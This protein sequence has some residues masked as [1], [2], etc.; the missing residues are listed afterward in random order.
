MG[1]FD[2]AMEFLDVSSFSL[3][4]GFFPENVAWEKNRHFLE[5]LLK[6]AGN[7]KWTPSQM[8]DH[9]DNFKWFRF[10]SSIR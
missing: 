1:S 7:L 6:I 9:M 2:G 10:K 5:V 3:G 4:S 8:T